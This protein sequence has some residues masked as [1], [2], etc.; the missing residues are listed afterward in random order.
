MAQIAYSPS[1]KINYNRGKGSVG[2]ICSAQNTE[3]QKWQWVAFQRISDFLLSRRERKTCICSLCTSQSRTCLGLWFPLGLQP[4]RT[5]T[6]FPAACWAVSLVHTRETH[7]TTSKYN[8][9]IVSWQ[10]W[11]TSELIAWNRNN[12]I[13]TPVILFL[14]LWIHPL[15]CIKSA[16]YPRLKWFLSFWGICEKLLLKLCRSLCFCVRVEV[17]WLTT[18]QSF[19]LLETPLPHCFL[20]P[21]CHCFARLCIINSTKRDPNTSRY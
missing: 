18:I 16:C 20:P 2:P 12:D 19:S 3:C 21:P 8:D 6:S 10:K 13:I 9:F 4:P 17:R 11:Y 1:M 14:L 5:T 15:L 7:P